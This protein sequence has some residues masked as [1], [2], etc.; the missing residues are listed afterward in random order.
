MTEHQLFIDWA[1]KALLMGGLAYGLA[2]IGRLTT[3]VEALN[4]KIAVLIERTENHA[5][6]IERHDERLSKIENLNWQ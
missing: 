5:K 2:L 4:I 6:E 1:F 3:S